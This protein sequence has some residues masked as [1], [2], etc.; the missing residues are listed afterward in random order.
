MT[1]ACEIRKRITELQREIDQ[2]HLANV[3]SALMRSMTRIQRAADK[4]RQERLQKIHRE[5]RSMSRLKSA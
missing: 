2:I 1:K 3:D 5:L 4:G